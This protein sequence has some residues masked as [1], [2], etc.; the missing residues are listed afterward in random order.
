MLAL[1]RKDG[2]QQWLKLRAVA[3]STAR[4]CA[5]GCTSEDIAHEAIL[6][7]LLILNKQAVDDS[8]Q[9][10]RVLVK[11]RACDAI[12]RARRHEHR[13]NMDSFITP[14]A[15]SEDA[16]LNDCTH[17]HNH[18]FGRRQR[19]IV[20]CVISGHGLIEA[21]QRLGIPLK[22]ARRIARTLAD[23]LLANTHVT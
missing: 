22:E 9:L 18:A 11:R 19:E 23:K 12:R 21:A 16:P 1:M 7:L 10:L 13:S 5:R 14:I 4:S 2:H 15:S 6:S 17:R 3:L 8:E 20:A